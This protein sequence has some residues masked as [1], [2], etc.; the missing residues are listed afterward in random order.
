MI[1]YYNPTDDNELDEFIKYT[2]KKVIELCNEYKINYIDTYNIFNNNK[3]FIYNKNNH[4]P[5]QDGYKLIANAVKNKL[6]LDK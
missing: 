2:N 4:Y 6:K 3:H 5:N 1:G